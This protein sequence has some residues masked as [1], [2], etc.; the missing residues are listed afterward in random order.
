MVSA[1][2]THPVLTHRALLAYYDEFVRSLANGRPETRGTYARALREYLRWNARKARVQIRSEDVN[3]Y[4]TYLMQKRKLRAASVST[5]LTALRRFCAYLVERGVLTANP[6]MLVAG[7]PRP[8]RH[9]REVLGA[10][11]VSR[12][13]AAV[14]GNDERSLRD[15]AWIALMLGCGLSE[16]EIIRADVGDL[17]EHEGGPALRVQGKG[18]SSKD[19]LVTLADEVRQAI[20]AYLATRAALESHLP[21]FTS[22]GNRTRGQRMTT[23]GVRD[24]INAYLSQAGI[25]RGRRKISPYSLRHT[26]AAM[27]AARGASAAEIRQR[28]RLGTEATAKLYLQQTH[29]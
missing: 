18:R 25:R 17:I 23:R 28:M 10:E 20:T 24:R 1:S 27:L 11:E 12:L 6:A 3:R 5:Y 14:R 13:Q 7:S 16:I 22:A 9:S 19:A 4:R 2:R 26:A 29:S 21:L 15:R 8:R